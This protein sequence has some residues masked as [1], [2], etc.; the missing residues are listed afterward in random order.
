MPNA[1]TLYIRSELKWKPHEKGA[2]ALLTWT[3]LQMEMDSNFKKMSRGQ[4]GM[5]LAG[6]TTPPPLRR[7]PYASHV[8]H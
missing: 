1:R 5:I 6:V 4:R 2:C 7:R 8:T 3:I